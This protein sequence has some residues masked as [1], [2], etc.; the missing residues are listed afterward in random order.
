VR[1][2]RRPRRSVPVLA[3]VVVT[4]L[5]FLSA[6]ALTASNVVASSRR[7]NLTD[8]MDANELKPANC[9]GITVTNIVV[10]TNGTGGADLILG[11]SVGETI[12]TQGGD[13]CALG[14][15]GN[16]TFINTGGN[17][18]CIGGPGTDTN[19]FLGFLFTCPTFIQ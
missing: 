12:Q 19:G 4:S 3:L 18:V 6:I 8:A 9:N 2:R 7:T 13:D 10:G 11:T 16:D 1:P 14:G 17:D 15:G 5:S